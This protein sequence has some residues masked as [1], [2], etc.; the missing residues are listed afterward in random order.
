MNT[1]SG[2]FTLTKLTS[3]TLAYN[4]LTGKLSLYT[5]HQYI[6]DSN[7]NQ[8]I[9]KLIYNS[10]LLPPPR[11]RTPHTHP[12]PRVCV[13]SIQGAIAAQFALILVVRLLAGRHRAFRASVRVMRRTIGP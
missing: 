12:R 9:K 2:L 4:S 13:R 1:L 8:M 11:P 10:P 5:Y 6:M 3:L 7:H